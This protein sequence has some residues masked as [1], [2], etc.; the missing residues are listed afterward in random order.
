MS[1]IC[2]IN[3]ACSCIFDTIVSLLSNVSGNG[4]SSL[5]F[6]CFGLYL[7]YHNLGL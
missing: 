4:G 2:Y 3:G 1:N 7:S 5:P 6:V